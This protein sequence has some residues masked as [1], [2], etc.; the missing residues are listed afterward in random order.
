MTRTKRINTAYA[1]CLHWQEQNDSAKTNPYI[2]VGQQYKNR[3]KKKEI[4]TYSYSITLILVNKYNFNTL[5]ML[6][7]NKSSLLHIC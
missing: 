3:K 6:T 1:W 7:T 5:K 2:N 4:L